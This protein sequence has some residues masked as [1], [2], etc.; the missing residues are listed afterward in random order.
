M[1]GPRTA[2]AVAEKYQLLP[3]VS[4][5][6]KGKSTGIRVHAPLCLRE[7]ATPV[8]TEALEDYAIA[9]EAFEDGAF[10]TASGLWRS[11]A[12]R[13]WPGAGPSAVMAEEADTLAQSLMLK[14]WTGVLEARS[15]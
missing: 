12:D 4:I 8:L 7:E 15:K 11:L 10:E 1:I 9:L 14:P 5:Q 2:A 3:I 6:V 13:D